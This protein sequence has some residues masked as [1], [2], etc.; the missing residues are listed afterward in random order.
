MKK[1]FKNEKGFTLIELMIVIAILGILAAVAIPNFLNARGKAQDASALSTLEAVKTAMEMYAADNGSYPA[2]TY[3]DSGAG[4]ALSTLLGE[5][6]P[7]N[8]KLDTTVAGGLN[9]VGSN[10]TSYRIFAYGRDASHFFGLNQAGQKEGPDT[11]AALIVISGLD[12]P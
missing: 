10:A 7:T 1:I 8:I 12:T 6:F 9:A 11:L 5:D 2:L 4:N 3:S